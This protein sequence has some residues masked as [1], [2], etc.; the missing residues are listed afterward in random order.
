M[1]FRGNGA[2]EVD[3]DDN[4]FFFFASCFSFLI[5]L[6]FVFNFEITCMPRTRQPNYY[7]TVKNGPRHLHIYYPLIL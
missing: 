2:F 4:G 7:R 3:K 6:I 1:R 5:I